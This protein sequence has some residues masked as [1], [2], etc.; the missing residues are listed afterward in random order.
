MKCCDVFKK[1]NK[2]LF[3]FL[4]QIDAT[5]KGYNLIEGSFVALQIGQYNPISLYQH[6]LSLI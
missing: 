1:S 2:K 6:L 4:I 5:I 3:F